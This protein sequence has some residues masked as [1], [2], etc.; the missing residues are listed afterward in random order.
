MA[1]GL[2]RR[3]I[4]V[5]EEMFETF[6]EIIFKMSHNHQV[7]EGDPYRLDKLRCP[8]GPSYDVIKPPQL[9]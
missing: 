9:V 1:R 8:E 7:R 6:G 4:G 5:T 2:N 3:Q